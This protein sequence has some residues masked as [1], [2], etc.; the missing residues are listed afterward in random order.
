MTSHAEQK[1]TPTSLLSDNLYNKAKFIALILLPASGALYFGLASIWG[2]PNAEQ[3]VG[4]ITVVDTFLGVLLGIST[5]AY[6]RSDNNH[7][8]T[9][10][11]EDDEDGTKIHLQDLDP[12]A[13]LTKNQVTF[14][15]TN[16]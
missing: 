4:T 5:S 3:V 10:M 6:N 13:L 1:T 15:I 8:G 9:L 14:K 12:N 7:D 16:L 11:L 2:L